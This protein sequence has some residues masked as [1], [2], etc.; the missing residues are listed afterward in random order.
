MTPSILTR[1]NIHGRRV[2]SKDIPGKS[3]WGQSHFFQFKEDDLEN[4]NMDTI[5]REFSFVYNLKSLKVT[6]IGSPNAST[7]KNVGYFL[8]NSPVEYDGCQVWPAIMVAVLDSISLQPWT[9]CDY[10][11]Q[12][13]NVFHPQVAGTCNYGQVYDQNGVGCGHTR[14]ENYFIFRYNDTYQMNG[15][16]NFLN[17]VPNNDYIIMYSWFT[18]AYSSTAGNAQLFSTLASLGINTG[19]LQDNTSFIYFL[20]KGDP[21]TIAEVHGPNDSTEI[22]LHGTMASHWNRGNYISTMIGPST[23]WE[24]LHWNQHPKEGTPTRDEYHMEILGLNSSTDTWDQLASNIQY[25]TGKD[26]SL[27][28][29][30]ATTYP[31]LKLKMFNEDDSLYTPSQ[32]NYW[33]VYHDEVP[34]A[35]LNPNYNYSLYSGEISEGDTL[36]FSVGIENISN[37][38]MDSLGVKFYMYDKNRNRHN[39][40]VLKLDSLRANRSLIASMTIDTTLGLAGENSLWVEVNP[41][42]TLHQIEKYHFNNLGEV[43]FKVN[44][45]NINPILDVTFDAIHILNGDI[46]SG[47]PLITIQLHDENKFLALND[48]SKFKV[49]LRKPGSSTNELISFQTPAYG[50]AMRFTPAVLPKNSCRI[51]WEPTLTDDGTYTLEVEATDRSNN[52]SGKYNYKIQ[53]EVVNKSSITEV[54]NYP[55]PFSTSTRFVFTLTGN[56]IPTH[57][58]IQIMTVSGKIVREIMLNELG[59]VHVGRNITDYA[60]DGKDEFGDQLANGVYLYRVITDLNGENIEHRETDI[61]KYFKRGWGKMY[62]MR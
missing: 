31:Y 37:L 21:S 30:N 6:T 55:N 17:S 32:M 3:G 20:K 60:W 59:N 42:D 34:E 11:V 43:K 2:H 33:R 41:F 24:S 4:I 29:I 8:N 48:T 27:S 22:N 52:E 1:Q 50:A 54:L 49:Y 45:D 57:M 25:S 40:S 51:D 23:R 62:L 47:K 16:Q 9:T 39:L 18:T 5:P 10:S 28:W 46:V 7:F 38:P 14:S 53:F 15:F 26:T 44:R 12:Q 58:K 36:H 19:G 61:D 35:A 56:E 13:A